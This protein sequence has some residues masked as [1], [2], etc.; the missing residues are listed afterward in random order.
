M[1]CKLCGAGKIAGV[2]TETAR[3]WTRRRIGAGLIEI[4]LALNG[5]TCAGRIELGEILIA[6]IKRH[7]QLIASAIIR[8]CADIDELL[9]HGITNRNDFN[10]TGLPR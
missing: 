9:C 10:R 6:L 1:N 7:P 5:T 8:D 3:C 4:P 2:S